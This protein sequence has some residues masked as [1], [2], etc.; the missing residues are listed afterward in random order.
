MD[1]II[2]YIDDQ[3]YAFDL[4]FIERVVSIVEIT[5]LPNANPAV[6]GAINLQGEIV[7][8]VNLRKLLAKQERSLELSDKLMISNVKGKKYAL[9][10]DGIQ[11][12]KNFD[13]SKFIPTKSIF[14][15][16]K[17]SDYVIKETG[18]ITLIYDLNQLLQ[19]LE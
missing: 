9:W 10:V 14:P 5:P 6:M 2:F 1:I 17:A 15:E 13:Q 12:I 19:A 11:E 8:V 16:V 7:P 18:K 4:S 3:H